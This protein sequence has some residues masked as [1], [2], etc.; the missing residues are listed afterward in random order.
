MKNIRASLKLELRNLEKARE[1]LSYSYEKCS[2]IG[3]HPSLSNDEL[4]AFEAL[5]ARFSRLSDIVIQKVL[6]YLDAL[7]LEETGTI[8]DRI[9]RAEKKELINSAEDLIQIRLL[10]NEIAHEYKPETIYAIFQQVLKLSP[11]LLAAVDQI[12]EKSKQYLKQK[13]TN[14]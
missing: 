8:R 5:A 14:Q 9:N 2:K 11:I 13:G 4:E 1:I 3:V 10:R 12:S 6:R 7:D